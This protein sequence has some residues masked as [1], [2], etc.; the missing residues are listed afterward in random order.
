MQDEQPDPELSDTPQDA[1]FR[2]G[3]LTYREKA[4]E[5]FSHLRQTAAMNLGL[6]Y[7]MLGQDDLR[8]IANPHMAELEAAREIVNRPVDSD[9]RTAALATVERLKDEPESV[10]VYDGMIHDAAIVLWLCHQPDSVCQKARRQ[11]RGFES[12]IDAWADE[13]GI[14]VGSDSLAEATQLF[15]SLVNSANASKG[16]PDKDKKSNGAASGN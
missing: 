10:T 11:P 16:V 1:A 9:E 13:H 7:W 8:E 4:L 14:T 2:A 12:K 5:P 3:D 15:M 6:R